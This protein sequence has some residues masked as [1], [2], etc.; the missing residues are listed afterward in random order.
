MENLSRNLVED[1]SHLYNSIYKEDDSAIL[2][3]GEQVWEEVEN[4]V[5]SLL[6]EGYDLSDYTWEEMYESYI[7]EAGWAVNLLK[8]LG[9]AAKAAA[10]SPAAAR[11]ASA[12]GRGVNAA[13]R[14][15]KPVLSGAATKA[16]KY[17]TIGALGLTADE[18]LTKGAGRELIGKGLE[19]SRKLGPTLRGEP[20]SDTAKPTPDSS[21]SNAGAPS[22]LKGQQVLAKKDGV[23]GVLDK[24]TGEWKSGNWDDSQSERYTTHKKSKTNESYD[25]YDL[26]LEYLFSEGHVDTLDEAHYVMM[27]MDAD[28][29]WSIIESGLVNVSTAEKAAQN[30]PGSRVYKERQGQ[31]AKPKPAEGFGRQKPGPANNFGRGF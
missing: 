7:N 22:E 11:A 10:K 17:G 2:I 4:W 15:A 30:L 19:Q 8:G 20:T 25:A 24:E 26:V 9:T 16:G 29:I 14:G 23:E 27:E 6:E 3:A 5:N 18:L 13:A 28:M 1:I 31:A 12:A 21:S